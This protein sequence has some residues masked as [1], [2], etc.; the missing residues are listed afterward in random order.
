MQCIDTNAAAIDALSFGDNSSS[1]EGS[2]FSMCSYDTHVYATGYMPGQ[3]GGDALVLDVDHVG[4]SLVQGGVFSTNLDYGF[5]H[6]TFRAISVD[7][8]GIYAGGMFQQQDNQ[9]TWYLR[10]Y[11]REG[12]WAPYADSVPFSQPAGGRAEILDLVTGGDYVFGVG[13]TIGT[14]GVDSTYDMRIERWSSDGILDAGFTISSNGTNTILDEAIDACMDTAAGRLCV[15]WRR[16]VKTQAGSGF[17]VR[18]FDPQTGQEYTTA[19]QSPFF[20]HPLHGTVAEKM[21]LTTAG[22]MVIVGTRYENADE[23]LPSAGYW[24]LENDQ[25]ALQDKGIRE[26][27]RR[28]LVLSPLRPNPFTHAV[29]VRFALPSCMKV[30]LQIYDMK[31]RL[32]ARLLRGESMSAGTHTIQWQ[33]RGLS[34]GNYLCRLKAGDAVRIARVMRIK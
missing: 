27:A 34:A 7:N 28:T 9:T 19:S 13:R 8:N 18:L 6:N 22:D 2:V 31:G 14:Y 29:S 17:Q 25:V 3:R 30:K 21:A 15:L 10:R 23:A 16:G 4:D 5:W 1:Y 24:I 11:T 20:R 33:P 32:V 12:L 26:H